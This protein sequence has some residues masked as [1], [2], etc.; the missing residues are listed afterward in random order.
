MKH[1]HRMLWVLMA[2]VF[3]GA[4]H[5]LAQK[6]KAPQDVNVVNLPLDAQENVLV[7]AP[8]AGAKFSLV[9]IADNLV[10]ELSVFKYLGPF[11]V[12]GWD[13][14]TF[15]NIITV[16]DG[17]PS[18]CTSMIPYL[19]FNGHGEIPPGTP[20][21]E[22]QP[23]PLPLESVP[24]MRTLVGVRGGSANLPEVNVKVNGEPISTDIWLYLQR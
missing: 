15:I 11:D 8:A 2:L 17:V 5:A 14:F 23:T 10:P 21:G 12:K 18:T 4:P 22:C 24:G 19:S 1:T 6:V 7:S 9:Q 20:T 3:I 13:S 16:P